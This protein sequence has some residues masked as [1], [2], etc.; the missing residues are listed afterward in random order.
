M[1]STTKFKS[2]KNKRLYVVN[3]KIVKAI[4]MIAI[5]FDFRSDDVD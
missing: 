4:A 2:P 5:S 3:L 1:P